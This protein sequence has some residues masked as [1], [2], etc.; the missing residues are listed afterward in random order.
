MAINVK[1]GFDSTRIFP[2]ILD[3]IPVGITVTDLEGHI[4]YYNEYCSKILERKPEYIGKDI[5]L[6]HEKS[7]SKSKI[8][9]ML[10]EFKRGRREAFVYDTI[11]YGN[12]ITVTL[13]PVEI[14]GKLVCCVQSVTIK[15]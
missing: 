12:Q 10:E 5:R 1:S 11:R 14:E 2:V 4:L 9:H 8:D 13:T 3:K 7:E 6:C 15:S